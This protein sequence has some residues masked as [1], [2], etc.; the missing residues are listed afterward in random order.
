[1]GKYFSSWGEALKIA[2]LSYMSFD[3]T[4]LDVV[5]TEEGRM[6]FKKTLK[7]F[8]KPFTTLALQVREEKRRINW[9]NPSAVISDSRLSP[10]IASKLSGKK[11]VLIINQAKILFPLRK[12][13]YLF[14]ERLFG[15]MLGVLWDLADIIVS[16]DLPPP[17]NISK[18][19]MELKT[20]EKKV[21][22]YWV[23]C[24]YAG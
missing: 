2:S 3:A 8:Y 4:P 12:N 6:S 16:P 5:W 21:G 19:S 17:Y 14:L 24:R 7:G 20:I 22:L 11:S 18:F 15:E 9:L 10:L 13:V 23:L 1:M